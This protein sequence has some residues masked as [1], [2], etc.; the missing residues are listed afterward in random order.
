MVENS[1]GCVSAYSDQKPFIRL[2]LSVVTSKL[3]LWH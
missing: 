3:W 1:V 2:E